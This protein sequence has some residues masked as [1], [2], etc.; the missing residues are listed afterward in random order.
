MQSNEAKH[1]WSLKRKAFESLMCKIQT[2]NNIF[3]NIQMEM[4][5]NY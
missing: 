4:N 2:N 1:I 5:E 3:N